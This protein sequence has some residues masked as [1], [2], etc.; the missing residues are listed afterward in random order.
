M[1]FILLNLSSVYIF[2]FI[3][4]LIKD[5]DEYSNTEWRVEVISACPIEALPPTGFHGYTLTL[6]ATE[7]FDFETV[8]NCLVTLKMR[9]SHYINFQFFLI[10][11]AKIWKREKRFSIWLS[12]NFSTR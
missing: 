3:K 10:L 1:I 6:R 4:I 8:S 9:F 12:Q 5:L 11:R 7:N 2:I